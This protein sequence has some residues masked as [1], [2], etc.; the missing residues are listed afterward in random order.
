MIVRAIYIVIAGLLMT[1]VSP[2][3]IAQSILEQK[4]E[5]KIHE[6]TRE[7]YIDSIKF[8]TGVRFLYTDLVHPKEP[9]Q[10]TMGKYSVKEILDSLFITLNISY[11]EKEGLIIL[12][13]HKE[14]L[15]DEIVVNGK[16]ISKKGKPV[17]F[18]TI[19]FK[20]S[21]KGTI[22][23]EEGLFRLIANNTHAN[24]TLVVSCIGFEPTEILS[25]EYK[26]G[27][28]LVNLKPSYFPIKD[29][30]VRPN[31]PEQ[32]VMKSYE[33][34]SE[35]HNTKTSLITAF[36]RESSKQNEEYIS[37]SEA[38]IEINKSSY[39]SSSQDLIRL[40]KGRNGTN[41]NKSDLVNL[42][43]EG[44][45]YN[46]LRL[47]IAKYGSYF[48]GEDAL[49]EC[50]FKF[51]KSIVYNGRQTYVVWFDMKENINYAGY[52]GK[53]YIDAE[54]L[55]LVRAE[56][57]LSS[58]GIKYARSALVRKTPKGYRVKPVFARYEVEYRFYSDL[59]NLH[60][61]RNEIKIKVR[62][63][64]GKENKGY[65]CDFTSTAEFVVTDQVNVR[66]KTIRYRDAVKQ[67]DVLVK[68]VSD[69]DDGFWGG[70][71]VI[72]PEEPLLSTIEKLQEQ[73]VL[74]KEDT[75]ISKD[76]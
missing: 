8:Q 15:D 48:Y 44:G 53:M 70:D 29:V 9:V 2:E 56:F 54:S 13:P 28:L 20:R 12:A 22:A 27:N 59:W 61:A 30:I 62:K 43:V 46:G 1:L 11:I 39:T 37:L 64:R 71:N 49:S 74:F 24:D 47:D 35:N 41:I 52:T 17:P 23:N 40:M 73:G 50:D 69:T 75:V 7:Q 58:S 72:V 60:Y 57:E 76:D 63:T 21:S 18:A 36:F 51:L 34:I 25:E 68:Q 14:S 55:A 32:L 31:N 6:G 42:V 4:V 38:L 3:I 67:N 45:L 26:K 10:I 19:Y 66:K 16:I 65:S 5:V 33:A